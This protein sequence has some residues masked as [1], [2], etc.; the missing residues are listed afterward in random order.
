[1]PEF[2][3]ETAPTRGRPKGSQ[4]KLT[5]LRNNVLEHFGES[6]IKKKAKQV[7]DALFREAVPEPPKEGEKPKEVNVYAAKVFLEFTI[8]RAPQAVQ[9]T[10]DEP[11]QI[12]TEDEAQERLNRYFKQGEIKVIDAKVTKKSGRKNKRSTSSS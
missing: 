7:L 3:S 9:L 8:G 5:H 11:T 12:W 10:L 2:T 4:N 1:M 6:V